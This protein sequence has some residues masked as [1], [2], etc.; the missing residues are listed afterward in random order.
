MR[1]SSFCQSQRDPKCESGETSLRYR[2]HDTWHTYSS[3]SYSHARRITETIRCCTQGLE[4]QRF[5]LLSELPHLSLAL[6]CYRPWGRFFWRLEWH[7]PSAP[8]VQSPVASSQ[9]S[10][11]PSML[12]RAFHGGSTTS[13]A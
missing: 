11:P 7:V 4:Y 13:R 3:G 12:A 2:W 1:P 10:P 5:S 6:L 8:L 9:Q